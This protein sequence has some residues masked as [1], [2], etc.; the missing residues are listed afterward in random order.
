MHC[1]GDDEPDVADYHWYG[2]SLTPAQLAVCPSQGGNRRGGV[3]FLVHNTVRFSP[4]MTPRW[5]SGLQLCAIRVH[6]RR[7]RDVTF[8][9]VYMDRPTTAMIDEAMM[10]VDTIRSSDIV[11]LGDFNSHDR[12]FGAHVTTASWHCSTIRL[13]R[14]S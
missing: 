7:R 6:H 8:V 1:A 12:S 13:P 9:N 4:C 11:L 2:S 14:R 10:F 3:A 5:R